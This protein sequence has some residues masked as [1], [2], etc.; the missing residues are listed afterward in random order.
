M[1]FG[2]IH[3]IKVD[4]FLQLQIVGLHAVGHIR[5]ESAHILAHGHGRNHLGL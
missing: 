1:A 4:Q 3:E 5:K 2:I